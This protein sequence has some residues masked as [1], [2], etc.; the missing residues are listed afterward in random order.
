MRNLSI[1]GTQVLELSSA[2]LTAGAFDLDKN[3]AY[4]LSESY[5]NDLNVDIEIFRVC[6]DTTQVERLPLLHEI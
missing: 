4:V 2:N 5:Q 6:S 1:S 3:C